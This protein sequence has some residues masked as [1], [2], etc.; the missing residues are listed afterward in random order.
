MAKEISRFKMS[1]V[2]KFNYRNA[3]YEFVL[4]E[5]W[6]GTRYECREKWRNDGG[7]FKC[8]SKSYRFDLTKKWASFKELNLQPKQETENFNPQTKLF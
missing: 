3:Y 5:R 4:M 2:P 1:D 6:D 8:S 7:V